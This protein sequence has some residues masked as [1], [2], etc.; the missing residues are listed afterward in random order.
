[1]DRLV[2][3]MAGKSDAKVLRDEL[4]LVSCKLDVWRQIA[5]GRQEL[6]QQRCRSLLPQLVHG[7]MHRSIMRVR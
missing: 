5:V 7:A 2:R 3:I 4:Q 6:S 1:M